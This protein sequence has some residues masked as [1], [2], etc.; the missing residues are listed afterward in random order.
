[1]QCFSNEFGQRGCFRMVH[2]VLHCVG[3]ELKGLKKISNIIKK[4]MHT[5]SQ[6]ANKAGG[7][8]QICYSCFWYTSAG[9]ICTVRWKNKTKS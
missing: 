4:A 3:P 1:M 6:S 7:A 9:G 8:F 2:I 5:R